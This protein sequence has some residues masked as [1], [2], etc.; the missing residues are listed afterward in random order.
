M[1]RGPEGPG[2]PA[3]TNGVSL[4]FALSLESSRLEESREGNSSWFS[5]FSLRGERDT[6]GD[7]AG[8]EQTR[9]ACPLFPNED[10][11]TA[12]EECSAMLP[13]ATIKS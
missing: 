6:G 10:F 3:N 9:G 2:D 12:V 5:W 8:P 7:A 13:V 1:G 4:Q 11:T